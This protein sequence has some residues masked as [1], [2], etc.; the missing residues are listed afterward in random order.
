[1]KNL[2]HQNTTPVKQRTLETTLVAVRDV[3]LQRRKNRITAACVACSAVVIAAVIMFKPT[4]PSSI[5]NHGSLVDLTNPTAFPIATTG[6]NIE[7]S[8][9]M[10]G[11]VKTVAM[12]SSDLAKIVFDPNFKFIEKDDYYTW[13]SKSMLIHMNL[14]T[15]SMAITDTRY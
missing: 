8:M 13:K 3:K 6:T 4:S 5:N 1:M 14:P 9:A 12:S 7:V 11:G 2:L 15:T 10:D